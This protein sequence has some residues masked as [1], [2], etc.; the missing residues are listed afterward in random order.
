M[1]VCILLRCY[2]CYSRT[3][4]KGISNNGLVSHEEM[5]FLTLL[6]FSSSEDA[7]RGRFLNVTYLNHFLKKSFNSNYHHDLVVLCAL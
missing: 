1:N 3:V 2:R 5:N 7:I 6:L 4:P